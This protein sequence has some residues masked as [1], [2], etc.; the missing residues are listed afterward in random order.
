MYLGKNIK[1][2]SKQLKINQL[3]LAEK[4]GVGQSTIS[5]WVNSTSFPDYQT[6]LKLRELLDVNLHEFIYADLSDKINLSDSHT[7]G[8]PRELTEGERHL[9][10][11]LL[12]EKDV[13]IELLKQQIEK[14]Q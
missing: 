2:L 4:L 8:M 1:H 14:G 7:E 12:K 13:V 5:G 11:R 3:Q 9:Y 6:L 10:E